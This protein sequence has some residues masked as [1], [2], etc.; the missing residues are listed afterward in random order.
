MGG[1]GAGGTVGSERF[2]REG[3]SEGTGLD[4]V[5][6]RVGEVMGNRVAWAPH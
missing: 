6:D 2:P 3:G 1:W 4:V 5:R